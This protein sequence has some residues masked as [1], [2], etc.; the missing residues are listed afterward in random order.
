MSRSLSLPEAQL[1]Q[2]VPPEV[3][4][5]EAPIGPRGNALP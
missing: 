4:V 2:V 3:A 1:Q 5:F